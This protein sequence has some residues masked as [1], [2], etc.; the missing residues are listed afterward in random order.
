MCDEII[1]LKSSRREPI[2]N[3]AIYAITEQI[4]FKCIN[5]IIYDLIEWKFGIIVGRLAY[6]C[7]AQTFHYVPMKPKQFAQL[8]F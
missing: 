2:F 6:K 7:L 8:L 1:V 3:D 5:I 4:I